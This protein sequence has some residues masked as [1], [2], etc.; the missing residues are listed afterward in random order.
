MLETKNQSREKLVF[1]ELSFLI[2]GIL[3]QVHNELGR[4]AREKQYADLVETKLK[5]IKISYRR[6]LE[7][8]DSGNKID[9][10]I[11]DKIVVELKAKPFFDGRRLFSGKKIPSFCKFT[12]RNTSQL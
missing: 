4:F 12:T 8:G 2:N 1:G 11:E 7:V 3:Y 10:S 6:E 9:F 5:A